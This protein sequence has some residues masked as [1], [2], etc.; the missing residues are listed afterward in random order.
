MNSRGWID[1]LASNL[2]WYVEG[3]GTK[4][5]CFFSNY[6]FSRS[7]IE[8]LWV[9]AKLDPL[10]RRCSRTRLYDRGRKACRQKAFKYVQNTTPRVSVS[11]PRPLRSSSGWLFLVFFCCCF[12]QRKFQY[13]AFYW[14]YLCRHQPIVSRAF[15][16]SLLGTHKTREPHSP[17]LAP[18]FLFSNSSKNFGIVYNLSKRSARYL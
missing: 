8:R 11:E 3:E 7:T 9:T 10:K 14:Y 6:M 16:S 15:A 4:K 13:F 5:V 12:K 18:E 17:S 1:L 2:L